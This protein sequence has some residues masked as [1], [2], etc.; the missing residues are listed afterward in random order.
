MVVVNRDS[1]TP[2]RFVGDSGA[3]RLVRFPCGSRRVRQPAHS[4]RTAAAG[5]AN[6]YLQPLVARYGPRRISSAM[7]L[8]VFRRVNPH[9]R[10][11]RLPV[12]LLSIRLRRWS[13]AGRRANVLIRD[14]RIAVIVLNRDLFSFV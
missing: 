7:L 9:R 8:I 1:S 5:S 10:R 12:I 3:R 4:V 13:V 11:G 2:A 14:V 6:I